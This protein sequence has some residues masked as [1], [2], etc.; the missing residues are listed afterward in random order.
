MGRVEQSQ[1]EI[2]KKFLCDYKDN[3]MS[4]LVGA[5]FSMNVSN[6]FL[7]WRT[8]MKEIAEYI[9]KD[10]IELHCENYIHIHGNDENIDEIKN[11]YIDTILDN[12]DFLQ[13]AS[14]YIQKKGYREAMDYYIE[15]H[16]P[17]LVVSSENGDI[18][19][20]TSKSILGTV[21]KSDLSVHKSLLR[22]RRFQNIYT[23]N[24]DNVLEF[25]SK[26]LS[27]E[28]PYSSYNI[29]ESGKKLSG[30]L[31]RNIIKIHGSICDDKNDFQF[32][33][34]SHLRYIIAQEDYD[35]YMEK[36]EAF[37]Y[38]MRIAMLQGV[39]CLVGF[40][41]TDPNYLA[42]VRW[43]S[44]ILDVEDDDKIYLLDIEG[45][46][47][48]DDLRLFYSNHHIV[49]I[50]L[51]NEN[52]LNQILKDFRDYEIY[53]EIID[54]EGY[55][56][57]NNNIISVLLEKKKQFE[58]ADNELKQKLEPDIVKYRK[59]ILDNFFKYLQSSDSEN[60]SRSY[61]YNGGD[62]S[63]NRE[64][65]KNDENLKPQ[66]DVIKPIEQ[67]L[68]LAETKAKY[69]DY[70]NLWISI[71]ELIEENKDLHEVINKLQELKSICRFSRII[72][73]QE[74][75]I[76]RLMTKKQLT[77]DKAYLFALA[78]SDIGQLPSY[79]RNYHNDDV[80]LN[81]QPIWIQLK[82]REDTLRGSAECFKELIDDSSI[83]EQVQRHLFHLNFHEAKILIDN[84]KAGDYWIQ[85]KA[86][87]MAV[88]ND[89]KKDALDLLDD[90]IK[91]EKNQSEKLFEV[92]MANFISTQWPNPY[93]M[94][95]FWKYGLEGQG[96]LLRSMMSTLRKIEE[97]PQRRGWIGTTTYFGNNHGDYVKSLRILQFI[98][99]SGIYLSIPGSY[100]FDIASWYK[101]FTNLYEHFPYPCFFYSIQYND[102][103]VQRRIGEDLTYNVKLQDFVQDILKKSLYA[104]GDKFTPLYLKNGMLNIIAIMYTAVNED[105]WFEL[106]KE[107][108]FE[109]LL[110]NLGNIQD[111]DNWVFNTRYA[112]ANIRKQE[113]V[114]YIFMQ[115]IDHFSNNEKIVSDLIVNNLSVYLLES[116]YKLDSILDFPRVLQAE[117]LDLLDCL[118]K[119]N[120]LSNNCIK[121]IC[122]TI[123]NTSIDNIPH[124]RIVLFQLVNLTMHN[125]VALDKIK[126]CFLSMDIWH[127]GLLSNEEFG[128]TEPMYI[129]LNLLNNKITWNDNEFEIIKDNLINN[130]SK[131]NKAH[132]TLHEDTFMKS[133]QA[134]YLSDML[135]Y[136]NG[137]NNKRRMEL[138]DVYS[139]IEGLLAYRLEYA[140]NIDLLMSEQSSDVNYALGNIYEGITNYGIE[141]YRNDIDFLID[142]AILKTPTALTSNIRC[143]WLI[144]KE[145]GEDLIELDYSDKIIKLLS[146]FKKS[147][148]WNRLDLRLAFNYLYSIAK[149]MKEL[150][151][152]NDVISFWMEDS[153]VMKFIKL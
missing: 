113:N 24:Y 19:L 54:N 59:L 53:K 64:D 128:W 111:Y 127:C 57:A 146:E 116:K 4:V 100:I 114:Y 45:K 62:T 123:I 125:T 18:E 140:N 103:E 47:I 98:I 66:S 126:E 115:L 106:F 30:N 36:H 102:K 1:K 9:Y 152:Q 141:K 26:V 104:I 74:R 132:K 147:E 96:D 136:I 61:I 81:K 48:H 153:F 137:L 68:S 65:C 82:E 8:L 86:M 112:L 144:I 79:Y 16:T 84:W 138:S 15:C 85:A 99:D 148:A 56:Q 117:T 27:E 50:N 151:I 120:M 22:C 90:A 143:I 78:V 40:S 87:R 108:V 88:Y 2:F 80:E 21:T 52:I 63:L 110:D 145:K 17:Q 6:K 71:S 7:S 92:V 58:N 60:S 11:K 83:Y 33:G 94:D 129:R 20:K 118:N 130:V 93:N 150:G 101:V 139:E 91:N 41:G 121:E 75:V 38:L 149:K 97:K 29:V 124:D 119:Y 105:D 35:T 13:L 32:D 34:D 70:R 49:V 107:T 5:G 31:S 39:F 67:S 133:I 72:F 37:S 10:K 134:R 12:E 122:E 77:R 28:E 131:Y 46:D 142:R 135:K 55:Q 109:K 73:P 23:T 89:N 14:K 42:W 44:D 43:M 3:K 25:T 76:S 95:E 51:W 69:F